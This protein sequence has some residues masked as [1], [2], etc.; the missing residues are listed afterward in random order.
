MSHIRA[1][2][3]L[4]QLLPFRS[5]VRLQVL[6]PQQTRAESRFEHFLAAQV[7]LLKD[8]KKGNLC[9]EEGEINVEISCG[10]LRHCIVV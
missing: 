1:N 7:A 2:R 6:N 4:I 10:H 3:K 5:C 8:S 9:I